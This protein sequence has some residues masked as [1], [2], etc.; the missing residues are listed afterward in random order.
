MT[1]Y[2]KDAALIAAG[3]ASLQGVVV[4]AGLRR[5]I[6]KMTAY[7]STAGT[8]TLKVYNV[9]TAGAANATTRIINYA[10]KAEETYLCPEAI[11]AGLNTGGGIYAEGSGI[12]FG[13]VASDT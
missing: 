12:S 5:K 10:L 7:N 2:I 9:P 6:T 11:G 8:L 1:I 3:V 13:F 4:P